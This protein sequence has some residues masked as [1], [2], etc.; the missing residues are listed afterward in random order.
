M[1]F[2]INMLIMNTCVP[3]KCR[4]EGQKPIFMPKSTP[5]DTNQ[6]TVVAAE[7][8]SNDR[9]TMI[10]MK[11]M[12]LFSCHQF[13]NFTIWLKLK[14]RKCAIFWHRELMKACSALLDFLY[15]VQLYREDLQSCG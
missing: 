9:M 14:K 10:N 3:P 4:N 2:V 15:I 1:P 8:Q 7:P 5:R 6:A 13:V 12:K 11:I